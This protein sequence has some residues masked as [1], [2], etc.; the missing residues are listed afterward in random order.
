[1]SPYGLS[2]TESG[3]GGGLLILSGL[4]ISGV[5][6]PIVAKTKW[7]LLA[8][9][10]GVVLIAACYIAFIW[11]APLGDVGG[12][13][14]LLCVLGAA[15][16]SI[17]PVAL[18]LLS[19]ISYPVGPE[20]SSTICWAGGQLLGGCLIIAG[21]AMKASNDASPPQ[22]LQSYLI[23]QAALAAGIAPLPLSLGLFD[24]KRKLAL[25]RTEA[26]KE[27]LASSILES[28]PEEGIWMD[29]QR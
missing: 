14:A 7:F 8:I 18:E 27:E 16:L 11:V 23:L 15:S 6:S 22:N 10:V 29:T 24:R 4:V 5:V 13:Y 20:V 1:M 25:K 28:A 9:K 17:V 19:E 26:E 21:D 12:L 2:D 3:I